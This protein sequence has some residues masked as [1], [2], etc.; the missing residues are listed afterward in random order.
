MA[1]I[2]DE[3]YLCI[4]VNKVKLLESLSL[5][6]AV[7]AQLFTLGFYMVVHLGSL[8]TDTDL[9]APLGGWVS[10]MYRLTQV[11]IYSGQIIGVG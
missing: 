7:Q 5:V 1:N 9:S 3:A 11:V 8:C 10:F 4:Q 2:Q 6:Y